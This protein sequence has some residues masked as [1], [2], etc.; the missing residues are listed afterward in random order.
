LLQTQDNSS[1]N[2]V[3][4]SKEIHF[5]SDFKGLKVG[6][7][8]HVMEIV[9][10]N[11]GAEVHQVPPEAYNNLDKGIVDAAFNLFA[12]VRVYSLY[13]VCDYFYTQSFFNGT[14]I[15]LMNLDA[16]NAMSPQDQEIMQ[17]IWPEVAKISCQT[18]FEDCET[19]KQKVLEAGKKLVD[20]TPEEAT[21]WA[22]E[23]EPTFKIWA[24]DAAALGIDSE[25]AYAV[26]DEWKALRKK[27]INK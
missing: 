15:V 4:K 11:G 25:V 23:A 1:Y 12:Q 27:Y 17:E 26:L 22:A 19:G 16:W 5:P 3:S 13:E 18:V 14:M 6:G 7:A 24:E 21:A 20:P 9:K 2:L 8:G 10:A